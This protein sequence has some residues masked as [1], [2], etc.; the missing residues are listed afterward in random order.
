MNRISKLPGGVKNLSDPVRVI[1]VC[2]TAFAPMTFVAA[3]TLAARRRA[4][5]VHIA[6]GHGMN[7]FRLVDSTLRRR[8]WKRMA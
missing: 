3:R 2:G 5:L 8:L 1:D 7:I 4:E 6:N